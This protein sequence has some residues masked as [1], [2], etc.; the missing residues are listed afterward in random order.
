MLISILVAAWGARAAAAPRVV[1]LEMAGGARDIRQEVRASAEAALRALGVE[2]VQQNQVRTA[3]DDCNVPS[4]LAELG[5]QAGASHI[6]EIQ[7]SY[8]NESY[9]LRLDLRDGGTGRILGSDSK[10][11]EICSSKDFYRA[12][13]DR[14]AALWTRVVREQGSAGSAPIEA[15]SATPAQTDLTE[16]KP[17]PPPTWVRRSFWRQP[18]PVF[19][20]GLAAGGAVL[21]GFGGHYLA[22]DGEPDSSCGAQLA[23][24]FT[25][26]TA[27]LGWGLLAGGSAALLGGV[28]ILI[29][30]RDEPTGPTV[31]LGPGRLFFSGSF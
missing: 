29:W 28:A 23:C 17:A 19:G 20:L 26:A 27:S 10:E 5:R 8:V 2:V 7:G 16:A 1:I 30:G 15:V 24:P 31:S 3:L 18:L 14:S 11:C 21:L 13:R 4:C 9:N 25:R 6:L 12:V 22:V